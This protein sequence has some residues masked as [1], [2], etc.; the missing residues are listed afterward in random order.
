LEHALHESLPLKLAWYTK[1]KMQQNA[2]INALSKQ[3]MKFN[4]SLGMFH[5]ALAQFTL[6]FSSMILHTE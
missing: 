1:Q 4:N 5:I 6:T 2:D 3:K